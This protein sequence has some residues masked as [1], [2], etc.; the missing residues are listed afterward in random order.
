VFAL[1]RGECSPLLPS[2]CAPCVEQ[3]R[4]SLRTV[5]SSFRISLES[6]F[7]THLHLFSH[8]ISHHFHIIFT[9][10]LHLFSHHFNVKSL[11]HNSCSHPFFVSFHISFHIIFTSHFTSHFTSFHITLTSTLFFHNSFSHLSSH[12]FLHLFSYHFQISFPSLPSFASLLLM[13]VWLP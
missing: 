11:F 9:S 13:F 5:S 2:T 10:I 3:I 1:A 12:L 8:L 6:I 7:T 4:N